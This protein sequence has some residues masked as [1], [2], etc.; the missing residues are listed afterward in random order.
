MILSV[1]NFDFGLLFVIT[2]VKAKAKLPGGRLI[3]VTT[4]GEPSLGRPKGGRNLL[5]GVAVLITGR[6]I[7][8]AFGVRLYRGYYAAVR[9]YNFF[10]EW[11]NNILR[12]SAAKSGIWRRQYP[13]E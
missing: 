12:T 9:R 4:I 10:S 3:G 5:I 7:L 1:V 11:T 6:L 8:A 13:H 2:F